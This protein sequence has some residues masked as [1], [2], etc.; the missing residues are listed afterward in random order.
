MVNMSNIIHSNI[1]VQHA[2]V[3]H[4]S[5]GQKTQVTNAV[6]K[7]FG[8]QVSIQA[9]SKSPLSNESIKEILAK[10]TVGKSSFKDGLAVTTFSHKDVTIILTYKDSQL[11][12]RLEERKGKPLDKQLQTGNIF[13]R[14]I[15]SI[16]K[17][18]N[19]PQELDKSELIFLERLSHLEPDTKLTA[20]ERKDLAD[21]FNKSIGNMS[22]NK[23]MIKLLEDP[24]NEE[25]YS[26]ELLSGL[27]AFTFRTRHSD[28]AGQIVDRLENMMKA[29]NKGEDISESDK[30]SLEELG[31]IESLTRNDTVFLL[32]DQFH[33]K[34]LDPR[35][36]RLSD[37]YERA[38][39]ILEQVDSMMHTYSNLKPGDLIFQNVDKVN[40]LRSRENTFEEIRETFLLDAPLHHAAVN[41]KKEGEDTLSHVMLNYEHETNNVFQR[42]AD[43]S[44]RLDSASLLT[45]N[46]SIQTILQAMYAGKN[47]KDEIRTMYQTIQNGLHQQGE[48]LFSGVENDEDRR[49]KSGL[50][51]LFS[52]LNKTTK[53]GGGAR[54]EQ[55]RQEM[56]EGNLQNRKMICSEFAAKTIVGGL[57]QQE[58]ELKNQMVE[59]LVS[60]GMN[61][62]QAKEMILPQSLFTLP[63]AAN[64][65]LSRVS[66]VR[67]LE[68]LSK[69][70]CIS[71]VEPHPLLQHI[72]K[73][74]DLKTDPAQE[75]IPLTKVSGYNE[76]EAGKADMKAPPIGPEPVR[77]PENS[78]IWSK[79]SDLKDDLGQK[80]F[81]VRVQNMTKPQPDENTTQQEKLFALI[82]QR[83]T[84][85]ADIKKHWRDEATVSERITH[86][87][88]KR[89]LKL[90]NGGMGGAY[91]L[92]NGK[93]QTEFI[94]KPLDEDIMTLNNRKA[95][96]SPFDG[97]NPTD[98]ARLH[99]PAYRTV[100]TEVLAYKVAEACG[101]S[102]ITPKTEMVILQNKAFHDVLDG[103]DEVND[104]NKAAVRKLAGKPD[105]EKLCSAQTFVPN[106]MDLNGLDVI[107]SQNNWTE[108]Q[109]DDFCKRAIDQKEFEKCFLFT[110]LTG[111]NDGNSGNYLLTKKPSENG[112]QRFGMVKID[113]A[114]CFAT[115]NRQFQTHL[116]CLANIEE[117]LSEAGRQLILNVN[118]ETVSQLIAHYLDNPGSIKAFKAR[119]AELKTLAI[120]PDVTL[121]DI[122]EKLTELNSARKVEKNV[123]FDASADAAKPEGAP[124]LSPRRATQELNSSVV[125][126]PIE[127]ENNPLQS[128]TVFT[129]AHPLQSS[130]VF[131]ETPTL[132]NSPIRRSPSSP[133]LNTEAAN[134]A[135]IEDGSGTTVRR[136]PKEKERMA[137]YVERMRQSAHLHTDPNGPKL[138]L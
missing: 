42:I 61:E 75:V 93:K 82:K 110:C 85:I 2:A 127:N 118:E 68:V 30:L 47:Y 96:A 25:K 108:R 117:P 19:K 24:K 39:K 126:T 79:W 111:D 63:F 21:I 70:G 56:M 57:L 41:F 77:K 29:L 22:V 105:K 123:E 76:D 46:E 98:R 100:Q 69:K 74:N 83:R 50:S 107:R 18:A 35:L 14:V 102:D 44:Y 6:G 86:L 49:V 38:D 28:N 88:E 115:A 124:R 73:K 60:T 53:E 97:S 66:P 92:R 134:F 52:F 112:E 136:E 36:A 59:Y 125:L 48:R 51:H 9:K 114:L 54:Y 113:N 84:E 103:V 87:N 122:H 130:T 95:V 43:T 106:E 26:P 33:L 15:S 11:K 104:E 121:K 8:H 135:G 89:T 37:A 91:Q 45:P 55:L 40:R 99:I 81:L 131:T 34:E 58:I 133:R 1:S 10:S 17:T 23:Q 7:L 72:V 132:K 120:K 101:F 64:E 4:P 62:A 31:I 3:V 12:T 78:S 16:T 128:S 138:D 116:E 27:K 94:I 32:I 119:I 90:C 129:E 13:T 20:Q 71:Q 80:R 137:D 5:A 65:S 67:L 109:L